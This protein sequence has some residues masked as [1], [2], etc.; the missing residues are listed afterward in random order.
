MSRRHVAVLFA[1]GTS[2]CLDW[3]LFS[4]ELC[5]AETLATG[6]PASKPPI[7][8]GTDL[9]AGNLPAGSRL[10]LPSPPTTYCSLHGT[11]VPR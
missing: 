2:G 1:I 5:S 4:T 3:P 11:P 7:R 10:A 9:P 8:T 6:P